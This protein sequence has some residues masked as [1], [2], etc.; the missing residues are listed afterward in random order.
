MAAKVLTGEATCEDIPYETITEYS[1]YVNSD[2]LSL[3]NI[4][5]PQEIADSAIE[6]AA[7]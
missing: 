6:C 7:E 4:G 3:M 1:T 5:L 2:A